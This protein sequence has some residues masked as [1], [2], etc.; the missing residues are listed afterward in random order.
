MK[1]I[2]LLLM[3]A[4]LMLAFA[5]NN[6]MAGRRA[7]RSSVAVS[8]SADPVK[9]AALT[10]RL[11]EIKAMNF[12]DL[13][14]REKKELRGELRSIRANMNQ[15]DGGVLYISGGTLLIIIILLILLL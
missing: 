8:K 1:K 11:M 14:R 7:E 15:L 5:P 4:L 13:S 3:T 12:S 6:V 2:T 9:S 10:S